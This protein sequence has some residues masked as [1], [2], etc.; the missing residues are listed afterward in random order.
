[1]AATVICHIQYQIDPFQLAAFEQY[2]KPLYE[3]LAVPDPTAPR[4]RFWT[5]KA[6]FAAA[7]IKEQQQQ[8]REAI[9][10]YERL[11]DLC[12]DMKPVLEER[13]RKIRVEH[14]ILF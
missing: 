6:G 12:S 2:A 14:L 3:T 11:L 7:C 13:I 10:L 8:W 4:E 9:K 1:M 5:C